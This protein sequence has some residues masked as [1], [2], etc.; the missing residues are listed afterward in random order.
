MLDRRRFLTDWFA[1]LLSFV[2]LGISGLLINSMIAKFYG[3]AALGIFNQVF[4]VYILGSQL[5]T[6]GVQF[7]VL[8]YIA[9]FHQDSALSARILA[10]ALMIASLAG[11][12][13]A[14]GF[15][16]IF[17]FAGGLLYS[18][19]VNAGISYMLP[20]LWAFGVNK[21]FLNALNGA[22]RNRSYAAFTALRYLLLTLSAVS[23]TV[24]RVEPSRLGFMFSSSELLLMLALAVQCRI[25]FPGCFSSASRQWIERHLRFGLRSILGGIAVEVNT[26]VDVLILG[27]FTSDAAVGIYSFAAFFVEGLLQLPLA[28]RRIVDP[29]LTRLVIEGDTVQL[30]DFLRKGRDLGA[31]LIVAV[32]AGAALLYP[33]YATLLADSAMAQ[34]SW[35]VFAILMAGA[36]VFGAYATF[37]GIFS[38]SGLPLAQTHFNLVMLVA[39]TGLNLVLAPLYGVHG[40][41]VA[42]SLSFIAGTLFFR[43]G[44]RHHLAVRF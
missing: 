42:T 2:L 24:L 3:A 26:R 33:F 44:V 10:A 19:E 43:R 11:I 40:A 31:L 29:V 9:E 37:S 30:R 38:Q 4:A 15:D 21:V 6:A 23:L 18:E 25:I 13:V 7:S 35:G 28:A 34:A 8:R 20:G 12:V 36:C 22:Q 27:V 17:H 32:A 5:A 14:V 16:A 41:A 1:N 39:N